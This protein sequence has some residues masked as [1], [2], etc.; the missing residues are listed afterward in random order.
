MPE[1]LSVVMPVRDG[2]HYLPAS[3]GALLASDLPR[4]RWELVVADD[5]SRD[6]SAEVAAAHGAAVV[7]VAGGPRGASAARNRGVQAARG[8]Y[9]LFV[10][11]D[12][13][14]HPGVLRRVV[15]I[16]EREPEV[17]AVF[18]AYDLAPAAPGLVTQYRNLLHRYFHERDAGDAVTFWAGCGAVRAEVFARLGGFDE[19]LRG[20]EDI[21]LGYRMSGA[22]YRIVLRPEIQGTHLKRWTLGGMV[23]T[24]VLDRGVPWVRV[25]RRQRARPPATLNLRAREKVCT[26]LVAGATLALPAVAVTGDARWLLAAATAA[27]GVLLVNAPLLAWFARHRGWG[28]ALGVVP[29][30]LL[31]YGLNAV[32]VALAFL[33]ERSRR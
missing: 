23:K 3:L 9:L 18:G 14:V 1:L 12:V 6:G 25:L 24:D 16:L 2:A 8:A 21:E 7:R 20:I 17:S 10:D 15:E 32:S 5:G 26:G 33:P 28:F 13:A 11:A 19:G 4:E 29:L 27:G 31:Y 30:R 22:G